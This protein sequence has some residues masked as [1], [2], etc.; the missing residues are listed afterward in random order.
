MRGC[1]DHLDHRHGSKKKNIKVV[2]KQRLSQTFA[3]LILSQLHQG[4]RSAGGTGENDKMKAAA[5]SNEIMPQS[6][7]CMLAFIT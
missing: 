7:V 3:Q 6:C 1:G 5:F 2:Q 4:I